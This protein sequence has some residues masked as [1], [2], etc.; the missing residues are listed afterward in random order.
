MIDFSKYD[1]EFVVGVD[2]GFWP[3]VIFK[4]TTPMVLY[5]HL[6]LNSEQLL[7]GF[8]HAK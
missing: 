5:S 4:K 3:L 8:H 7:T 2:T 1:K 6:H